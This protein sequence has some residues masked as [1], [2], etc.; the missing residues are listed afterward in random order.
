M[1]LV[2]A[3]LQKDDSEMVNLELTKAG[4]SVTN[5][6][7]TSGFLS[8]EGSVILCGVEEEQVQDVLALIKNQSHKRKKFLQSLS[9]CSDKE[10][11]QPP[12]E[13]NVSA[14]TVFVLDIEHF[15]KI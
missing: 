9:E 2:V 5:L 6:A 14:A 15:E 4:F 12:V 10:Q 8:A 11:V 3:V 1:K 13:V 7:S